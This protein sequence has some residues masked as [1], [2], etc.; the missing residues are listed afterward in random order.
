MIRAVIW[1]M[2]LELWRDRGALVL[3]F[4]LP[5]L[6]FAIFASIFSGAT[7]GSF[8]VR[9]AL[10]GEAPE[11]REALDDLTGF[12][13]LPSVDASDA[14]R[15]GRADVGLKLLGAD[16]DAPGVNTSLAGR[17][18][19][20]ALPAITLLAE[21]SRALAAASLE[22][23]LRQLLAERYPAQLVLHSAEATQVLVGG[24]EP[25]QWDR[26]E[27][28]LRDGSIAPRGERLIHHQPIHQVG[29]PSATAASIAYYTGATAILFLLLAAMQA[30]A[31]ALEERRNGISERLLLGPLGRARMLLGRFIFLVGLG[32]CQAMMIYTVARWAFALPA[33]QS[34]SA[35]LAMALASAAASS[36]LAL[37]VLSFCRTL[38][39]AQTLS[40]FL[41]LIIS[42]IGG[43][44]VPRYMMP[45]WLQWLGLATPN[46]WAIE[47]IYGV[48]ARGAGL[49]AS[50][51]YIAALAGAGLFCV[52]VAASIREP[53]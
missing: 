38:Q 19:L 52:A 27:Q 20:P 31:V 7:D 24:F 15:E 13:W 10:E 4:V 51:K 39:Q 5:S 11:L 42:A 37:V 40:A 1:V 8:H 36:G 17:A 29:V 49:M 48:L 9:V 33:P 45:E 21:P 3:A 53:D 41:V 50:S 2:A 16:V 32:L 26:L 22:G 14:V 25:Y 43:S 23:A 28:A 30:G 12:E 44:M 47:G 18:A 34:L 46:A 6:I 35:L